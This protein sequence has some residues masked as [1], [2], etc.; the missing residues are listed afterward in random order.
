MSVT[1]RSWESVVDT[2][3][4]F[5]NKH[6]PV[7]YDESEYLPLLI[8]IIGYTMHEKSINVVTTTVPLPEPIYNL[9]DTILLSKSLIAYYMN[10]PVQMD[11]EKIEIKRDVDLFDDLIPSAPDQPLQQSRSLVECMGEAEQVRLTFVTRLVLMAAHWHQHYSK[12]IRYTDHSAFHPIEF[13]RRQRKRTREAFVGGGYNR[14][15]ANGANEDDD[16][17]SDY[18]DDAN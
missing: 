17:D 11:T 14:G 1:L 16:D 12:S 8:K 13:A 6:L 4:R 18:T 10:Q 5:Y 7:I 9:G 3:S 15:E 2:I